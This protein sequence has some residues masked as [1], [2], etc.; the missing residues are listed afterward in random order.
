MDYIILLHVLLLM[1][2]LDV[3]ARPTHNDE[4]NGHESDGQQVDN[5]Y[6]YQYNISDENSGDIK[7]HSET[8]LESTINGMYRF[9]QPDGCMRTVRYTADDSGFH[10]VVT[11]EPSDCDPALRQ[12]AAPAPDQP[13]ALDNN[14]QESRTVDEEPIAADG[15][16]A[17][18]SSVVELNPIQ[19]P[20][21]E[22]I[23]E[24][25]SRSAPIPSG[26]PEPAGTQQFSAIPNRQSG[27]SLG[28]S[29]ASD[30]DSIPLGTSDDEE[31]RRHHVAGSTQLMSTSDVH[32]TSDSGHFSV[33]EHHGP[34]D[35][36]MPLSDEDDQPRIHQNGAAIV[37][38]VTVWNPIAAVESS[39]A[40]SDESVVPPVA[41]ETVSKSASEKTSVSDIS[42]VETDPAATSNVADLSSDSHLQFDSVPPAHSDAPGWDPTAAKIQTTD[43]VSKE[44]LIDSDTAIEA[45]QSPSGSTRP[46]QDEEATRS[47]GA[48]T[49]RTDSE[50]PEQ[51]NAL[52]NNVVSRVD[53]IISSMTVAEPTET[54]L[55]IEIK[56]TAIYQWSREQTTDEEPSSA[57]ADSAPT[58]VAS[59]AY[60]SLPTDGQNVQLSAAGT[61]AAVHLET[62]K[63][64][65][66]LEGGSAVREADPESI[67]STED[68][69]ENR[70]F[71]A[72]TIETGSESLD[73][74]LV[75]VENLVSKVDSVS[76]T[77]PSAAAAE[78]TESLPIETKKTVVYQWNPVLTVDE[79]LVVADSDPVVSVVQSEQNKQDGAAGTNPAKV[80]P[81]PIETGEFQEGNHVQKSDPSEVNSAIDAES[82]AEKTTADTETVET[83]SESLALQVVVP[84]DGIVSKVDSTSS[85]A[86]AAAEQTETLPTEAK[87]V[88]VYQW[89]PVKTDEETSDLDVPSTYSALPTGQ[90]VEVPSAETRPAV[91]PSKTG[92]LEDPNAVQETDDAELE[93]PELSLQTGDNVS[94]VDQNFVPVKPL[95]AGTE[96]ISIEISK[97][98]V[99]DVQQSVMIGSGETAEAAPQKEIEEKDATAAVSDAQPPTVPA[100]GPNE[101]VAAT[102][103][104]TFASDSDATAN[105]VADFQKPIKT[106][107]WNPVKTSGSD[108]AAN[109]W[110]DPVVKKIVLQGP[111]V[112]VSQ[113]TG[114]LAAEPQETEIALPIVH[115]SIADVPKQ[116]AAQVLEQPAAVKPTVVYQWNP[117]SDTREDVALSPPRVQTAQDVPAPISESSKNQVNAVTNIGRDAALLAVQ[118]PSGV[119]QTNQAVGD[120]IRRNDPVAN[121]VRRTDIGTQS[122]VQN[123]VTTT[124]FQAIAAAQLP[125]ESFRPEKPTVVYQWSPVKEVKKESDRKDI[126]V[127]QLSEGIDRMSASHIPESVAD[128]DKPE[129][130]R[131]PAQPAQRFRAVVRQQVAV[132]LNPT[133]LRESVQTLEVAPASQDRSPKN[134]P[135]GDDLQSVRGSV[136]IPVPVRI[137]TNSH[138]NPVVRIPPPP[139][140]TINRWVPPTF[141][142]VVRNG[143]QQ[144]QQ[145]ASLTTVHNRPIYPQSS[146]FLPSSGAFGSRIPVAGQTARN[147]V[148]SFILARSATTTAAAPLNLKTVPRF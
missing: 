57:V 88:V 116:I 138:S 132:P 43:D 55:P 13:S 97:E 61:S 74:Q 146:R 128:I 81:E 142:S 51:Q 103:T 21:V 41:D 82:N 19:T 34:G 110:S 76:L 2:T 67:H 86:A 64:E 40:L 108:V 136:P 18:Q 10:P 17:A 111:V 65:G 4:T 44:R 117:A 145:Q 101:N 35:Q 23:N 66:E 135:T 37:R 1:M 47:A 119:D 92:E 26:S 143:G 75:L 27:N 85:I 115:D 130:F 148:P 91:D 50:S 129:H 8:R 134:I 3:H 73:Q 68:T 80:D 54:V 112:V 52:I 137:A 28:G 90:E 15:E 113:P 121:S 107:E 100:D 79:P 120:P 122:I 84:L 140:S 96:E 14:D 127:S 45:V 114:Q 125:V 33:V 38:K 106:Y 30:D 118:Y 131:Q 22:S 102:A 144:R 126:Q 109:T 32:Q 59:F 16:D 124:S 69:A 99:A 25:E 89:N 46:E 83:G 123:A 6:K 24:F 48:E 87:K 70:I 77:A 139:E 49:I 39:G 60:S 72:E 7:S 63:T 56:K 94:K 31:S 71:D 42:E 147:A 98:T 29:P 105:S 141:Q 20:A 78:Q 104:A 58:P 36:A 95:Y 11:Y 62:S 12:V 93:Q 133:P 5:F 9:L 53:S